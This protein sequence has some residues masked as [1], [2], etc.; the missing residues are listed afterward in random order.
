M[1]SKNTKN[2]CEE[3]VSDCICYYGTYSQ[4]SCN[5]NN[6]MKKKDCKDEVFWEGAAIIEEL[7]SE[8]NVPFKAKWIAGSSIKQVSPTMIYLKANRRYMVNY[9]IKLYVGESGYGT[10]IPRINEEEVT[11]GI[12]KSNEPNEKGE[13]KL[14]KSFEI[15]TDECAAALDFLITGSECFLNGR[16][17]LFITEL[18]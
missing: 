13:V 6:M 5:G 3:K 2:C 16:G 15:I 9:D 18:K 11:S 14:A 8:S 12:A 10:V 7:P 17:L 1:K 4:S